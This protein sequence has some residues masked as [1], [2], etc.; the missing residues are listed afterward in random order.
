MR[1]GGRALPAAALANGRG[2]VASATGGLL[3]VV[4]PGLNGVLASAGDPQALAEG[5]AGA[6]PQGE[7][8]GR[9]ALRLA[10][11]RFAWRQSAEAIV[12]AFQGG[13]SRAQAA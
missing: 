13:S 3:D 4:R 6:L 8:F 7:R 9:G 1:P 10:E 5:L 11:G 2:V 12:A